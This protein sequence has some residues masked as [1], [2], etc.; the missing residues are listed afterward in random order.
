M[1]DMYS[2]VYMKPILE[3]MA[4]ANEIETYEQEFVIYTI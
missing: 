2:I 3:L 4:G 1:C